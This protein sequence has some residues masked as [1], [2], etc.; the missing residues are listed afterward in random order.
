MASNERENARL[1]KQQK[2]EAKL[3]KIIW[4]ILIAVILILLIMKAFEINFTSVKNYFSNGSFNSSST[5]SVYPYKL[6]SS[7]AVVNSVNDKLNILTSSTVTVL[8]PSNA[9]VDYTFAHGFATPVISHRGNYFCLIDQG[10]NRFR[11]DTNSDNI[12]EETTQKPILCADVSR[13]GKIVYATTSDDAKSTVTVVTKSLNES[14]C[15]DYNDGYVVD[16]AIDQSGKKIAIA[17]V[18]SSDAKL[19]TTVSTYSVGNSKPINSFEFIGT[20]LMDIHYSNSGDLFF[21]GT[22]CVSVIKG[23]K[24]QKIVY[25]IGT[26]NTVCFNYTDDGDL[27][28]IYSNYSDANENVFNYIMSSGKVKTSLSLSQRAKNVSSTG[29][30]ATVLFSDKIVNYSLTNGKEKSSFNCDDS[31]ETANRMSSKIFV[32]S[33]QII[34]VIE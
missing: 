25:D 22:D 29:G 33:H 28:Y 11:L 15:F 17:A 19:V 23:Q 8:N 12:Y 7:N 26:V 4:G 9:N 21:V 24:K 6:D 34:D 3:K 16:V 2:K 32:S 27:V 18:N 30:T 13:G 20:N 10:S 31:V 1:E 5:E 14:M